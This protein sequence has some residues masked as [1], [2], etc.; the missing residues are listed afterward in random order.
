M[1]DKKLEGDTGLSEGAAAE[2]AR[3]VA[4]DVLGRFCSTEGRECGTE[5]AA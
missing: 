1:S 4:A 2:H 3:Q 5:V